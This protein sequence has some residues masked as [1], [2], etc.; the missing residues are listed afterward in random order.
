MSKNQHCPSMMILISHIYY[1]STISSAENEM[2]TI[3]S[4][5]SIPEF[6]GL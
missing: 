3:I 2:Q 5:Y 4:P 1:L 6:Q